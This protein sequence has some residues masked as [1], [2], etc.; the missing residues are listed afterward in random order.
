MVAADSVLLSFWISQKKKT[1]DDD[2]LSSGVA[3]P[4]GGAVPFPVTLSG[5]AN[6][7]GY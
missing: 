2:V 7:W 1:P 5:V 3:L 4:F 6:R